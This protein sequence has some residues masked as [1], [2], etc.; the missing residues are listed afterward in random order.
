MDH[1]QAP[2]ARAAHRRRR[3]IL[4]VTSMALCARQEC[5]PGNMFSVLSSTWLGASGATGFESTESAPQY[6]RVAGMAKDIANVPFSH[7]SRD[8]LVGSSSLRTEMKHSALVLL[9]ALCGSAVAQNF[10][11]TTAAGPFLPHQA[12]CNL[13]T[14]SGHFM[15]GQVRCHSMGNLVAPLSLHAAAASTHTP[16]PREDMRQRLLPARSWRLPS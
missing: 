9:A 14:A 11:C 7:G 3:Q 12:S 15:A 2:S 13:A 10:S 16:P 8:R 4:A 5:P 6:S 1:N